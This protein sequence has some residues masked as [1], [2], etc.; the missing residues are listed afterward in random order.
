[1]HTFSFDLDPNHTTNVPM[2]MSSYICMYV[3][4]CITYVPSFPFKDL[5][6]CNYVCVCWS[7]VT[8]AECRIAGKFQDLTQF[9]IVHLQTPYKLKYHNTIV[10]YQHTNCKIDAANFSA[11][12]VRIWC[13]AELRVCVYVR[14]CLVQCEFI[15]Q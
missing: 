11:T 3:C 2:Y 8:V 14:T 13:M 6:I 4:T 5:R 7:L 1:M 10:E 9:T 12:Y 15:A